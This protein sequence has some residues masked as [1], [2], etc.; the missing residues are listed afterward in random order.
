MNHRS[1]LRPIISRRGIFASKETI[2]KTVAESSPK[3]HHLPLSRSDAIILESLYRW[4]V[5]FS[6]HRRGE[7]EP[8]RNNAQWEFDSL[9]GFFEEALRSCDA[10]F[11]QKDG[12]GISKSFFVSDPAG[13]SLLRKIMREMLEMRHSIQIARLEQRIGFGDDGGLPDANADFIDKFRHIVRSHIMEKVGPKCDVYRTAQSFEKFALPFVDQIYIMLDS[14]VKSAE[15]EVRRRL[16]MGELSGYTSQISETIGT[17][18]DTFAVFAASYQTQCDVHASIL[19]AI[20]DRLFHVMLEKPL[21]GQLADD[22]LLLS[23]FIEVYAHHPTL[24]RMTGTAQKRTQMLESGSPQTSDTQ[25]RNFVQDAGY[26][27]A[28]VVSG[29]FLHAVSAAHKDETVKTIQ[30]ISDAIEQ[31]VVFLQWDTQQQ[32][33]FEGNS[34]LLQANSAFVIFDKL[35]EETKVNPK[36]ESYFHKS[37]EPFSILRVMQSIRCLSAIANGHTGGDESTQN[38]AKLLLLSILRALSPEV[39]ASWKSG[40]SLN[41]NLSQLS[42]FV[43][44]STEKLLGS[45]AKEIESSESLPKDVDLFAAPNAFERSMLLLDAIETQVSLQCSGASKSLESIASG[46]KISESDMLMECSVNTQEV[47]FSHIRNAFF[48]TK[49]TQNTLS[50][51]TLTYLSTAV[52][53]LAIKA[54]K[55]TWKEDTKVLHQAHIEAIQLVHSILSQVLSVDVPENGSNFV[56]TF[57]WRLS[58]ARSKQAQTFQVDTFC[59]AMHTLLDDRF[60]HILEASDQQGLSPEQV[61]ALTQTSD[62][63]RTFRTNAID[64]PTDSIADLENLSANDFL[65]SD[66]ATDIIQCPWRAL[67]TLPKLS[68]KHIG[69][70]FQMVDTSHPL[71]AAVKNAFF[72]RIKSTADICEFAYSLQGKQLMESLERALSKPVHPQA[73]SK[74]APFLLSYRALGVNGFESLDEVLQITRLLN[75]INY[76]T[77]KFEIASSS[78]TECQSPGPEIFCLNALHFVVE[79]IKSGEFFEANAHEVLGKVFVEMADAFASIAYRPARVLSSPSLPNQESNLAKEYDKIYEAMIDADVEQSSH[80]IAENISYDGYATRESLSEMMHYHP[81]RATLIFISRVLTS[82]MCYTTE[83][84]LGAD[85]CTSLVTGKALP[86]DEGGVG[87]YLSF[88]R[89]MAK[90]DQQKFLNA[91]TSLNIALPSYF[92]SQI[93]RPIVQSW[94]KQELPHFADDASAETI[95]RCISWVYAVKQLELCEYSANDGNKAVLCNSL[96]PPDIRT[97]A[98]AAVLTNILSLQ[99]ELSLRTLLQL[100]TVLQPLEIPEKLHGKI[101]ALVAEFHAAKDWKAIPFGSLKQLQYA[102]PSLCADFWK[103]LCSP[104]EAAITIPGLGNRSSDA[105]HI[106]NTLFGSPDEPFPVIVLARIL[107]ALSELAIYSMYA[108]TASNTSAMHVVTAQSILSPLSAFMQSILPS[109]SLDIQRSI[110]RILSREGISTY[111][112]TNPPSGD[113]ENADAAEKHW[114]LCKQRSL[115][116]IVQTNQFSDAL[117]VGLSMNTQNAA[118]YCAPSTLNFPLDWVDSPAKRSQIAQCKQKKELFSS[119]AGVAALRTEIITHKGI[120]DDLVDAFVRPGAMNNLSLTDFAELLRCAVTSGVHSQPFFNAVESAVQTMQL[121]VSFDALPSKKAC[122]Q[123]ATTLSALIEVSNAI[124]Y[125]G[126]GNRVGFETLQQAI[127]AQLMQLCAFVHNDAHADAF[128]NPL[129]AKALLETICMHKIRGVDQIVYCVA[130]LMSKVLRKDTQIPPS[131]PVLILSYLTTGSFSFDKPAALNL[132]IGDDSLEII[133]NE[134]FLTIVTHFAQTLSV[135]SGAHLVIALES[136]IRL[137]LPECQDV[138]PSPFEALALEIQSERRIATFTIDQM[139]SICYALAKLKAQPHTQIA[140]HRLKE[141][142]FMPIADAILDICAQTGK[143]RPDRGSVESGRQIALI[144]SSFARSRVVHRGLFSTLCAK[145]RSS[146]PLLASTSVSDSIVFLQ[147]LSSVGHIDEEVI[148]KLLSLINQRGEEAQKAIAKSDEKSTSTAL[149]AE[150]IAAGKLSH[151]DCLVALSSIAKLKIH[152]EDFVRFISEVILENGYENEL[153]MQHI[154]LLISSLSRMNMTHS[155]LVGALME[156]LMTEDDEGG[157]ALAELQASSAATLLLALGH[158]NYTNVD[159]WDRLAQR[160][161]EDVATISIPQVEE[162]CLF[163]QKMNWRHEQMLRAIGE[164]MADLAEQNQENPDAAEVPPTIARLTLATLG[165]FLI[166]HVKARRALSPIAA[167]ATVVEKST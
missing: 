86:I 134:H 75:K 35:S 60:L 22:V 34:K 165:M 17:V 110:F 16:K 162:L 7:V 71:F 70:F 148:Q 81:I 126:S 40:G 31:I 14:L 91:V 89:E 55:R 26:T 130:F 84:E 59:Q 161:T 46:M 135:V 38:D 74:I 67:H 6:P 42:E 160:I 123:T 144:L 66:V 156:R 69:Y 73:V 152:N 52:L 23:T 159:A 19:P 147:A 2:A 87:V 121:Q 141:R 36:A 80:E 41:A 136:L 115:C 82:P 149:S 83:K 33:F 157:E 43:K 94:W 47:V 30:S 95:E 3:A 128:L 57:L 101:D 151:I 10:M 103:K 77:L 4:V 54:I 27:N 96:A 5:P 78:P 61:N 18:S 106:L 146:R 132:E 114:R 143:K 105:K 111:Q 153:S 1:I 113:D 20:H 142:V 138:Q 45:A 139:G 79:Q 85:I 100:C 122:F 15:S 32:R 164:H 166:N 28:T 133:M 127:Q 107:R 145:L 131:L 50:L 92:T 8:H 76:D 9:I 167:G 158:M 93:I 21:L 150:V 51:H 129:A 118:F 11:S 90:I 24:G 102:N 88:W 58:L 99:K 12:I 124:C 154:V 120:I 125:L 62:L 37:T 119:A 72:C 44:K 64:A 137:R 112:S 25:R 39:H 68:A 49:H 53:P 97:N 29:C 155:V 98:L 116:D 13:I 140:T 104:L 117:S 163:A 109:Q 48:S 108:A 65:E 63:I 56:D